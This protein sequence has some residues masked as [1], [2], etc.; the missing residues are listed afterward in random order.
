MIFL[1]KKIGDFFL[2]CHFLEI[3]FR[4]ESY[5]MKGHFCGT[6]FKIFSEYCEIYFLQKSWSWESCL[7]REVLGSGGAYSLC[8]YLIINSTSLSCFHISYYHYRNL[9]CFCIS[10]YHTYKLFVSHHQF[11]NY[12]NNVRQIKLIMQN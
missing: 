3:F 8:K 1:R 4:F 7:R 5:L 11:N 12:H 2:K 9:N 10:F 6:D